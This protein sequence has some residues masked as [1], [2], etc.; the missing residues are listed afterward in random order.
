MQTVPIHTT[1]D[2]E[3]CGQQSSQHGGKPEVLA[4][5][6]NCTEQLLKAQSLDNNDD[7][8]SEE[9]PCIELERSH[10]IDNEGKACHLADHNRNVS[11][12]VSD[13]EGRGT[14]ETESLLAGKDRTSHEGGCGFRHRFHEEIENGEEENTRSKEDGCTVVFE[15]V[16]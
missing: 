15:V 3:Y 1:V 2:E 8:E 12:R 11:N 13:A 14:I 7:P 9:F 6:A 4:H 10:E 5:G 16:E